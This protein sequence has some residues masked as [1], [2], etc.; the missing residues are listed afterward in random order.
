[1]CKAFRRAV[2]HLFDYDLIMIQF[3]ESKQICAEYDDCLFLYPFSYLYFKKERSYGSNACLLA[4]CRAFSR[5]CSAAAI[6]AGLGL[7]LA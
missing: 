5:S 2:K 3:D 7:R 4:A 1:M 6:V